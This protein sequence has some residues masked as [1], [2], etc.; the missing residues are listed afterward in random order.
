MITLFVSGLVMVSLVE[1]SQGISNQL[2]SLNTT[3]PF[4][5]QLQTYRI[6]ATLSDTDIV[7]SNTDLPNGFSLKNPRRKFGF[8]PYFKTAHANTIL[9]NDGL[10]QIS[11]SIDVSILNL[12]Q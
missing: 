2:S 1:F 12:K 9:F 8:K 5:H 10:E 4:Y 7:L 6:Q 3:K 11:L